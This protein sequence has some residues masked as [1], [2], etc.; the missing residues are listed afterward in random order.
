MEK[1]TI[2]QLSLRKMGNSLHITI[3]SVFVKEYQLSSGD[4]VLMFAEGDG[5]KLKVV[6]FA[7]VTDLAGIHEAVA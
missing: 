4:C 1:P 6:K 2:K 7:T 3:P 5:F